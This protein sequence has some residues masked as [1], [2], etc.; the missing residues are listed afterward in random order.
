MWSNKVRQGKLPAKTNKPPNDNG[1]NIRAAHFFSVNKGRQFQGVRAGDGGGQSL[2]LQNPAGR[3]SAI[4]NQ[5][6][7]RLPEHGR[8]QQT[9]KERTWRLSHGRFFMGLALFCTFVW[10][11]ISHMVSLITREAGKCSLCAQEKRGNGFPRE[12]QA[13]LQNA[14][15]G[16]SRYQ[17]SS[18]L[19]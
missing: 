10:P 5:R 3:R 16:Q 6:L 13:H 8:L 12:Q 19:L 11:E 7:P 9:E 15:R 2:F 18:E 14:Y 4:F 17:P 1:S